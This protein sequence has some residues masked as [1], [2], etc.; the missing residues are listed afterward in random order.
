MLPKEEYLEMQSRF[1]DSFV[2]LP[3]LANELLRLKDLL[4]NHYIEVDFSG[5][6]PEA[7]WQ[8]WWDRLYLNA[9]PVW[10]DWLKWIMM[11]AALKVIAV[12]SGSLIVGT[13]LSFSSL[14]MYFYFLA[15]FMR[16][17]IKGLSIIGSEKRQFLVSL[18]LSAL[19]STGA[20]WCA[21]SLADAVA[22][23]SK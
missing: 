17:R 10:F 11:L 1:Y 15:F 19:L 5:K 12:K 20:Y 8:I 14:L 4:D 18:I 16:F 7:A 21:I 3:P 2:K 22:A 9:V 6:K 13:L 23:M